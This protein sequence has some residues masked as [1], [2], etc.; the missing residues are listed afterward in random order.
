MA[1]RW[2]GSQTTDRLVAHYAGIGPAQ[3]WQFVAQLVEAPSNAAFVD[4][5]VGYQATT[6]PHYFDDRLL[7]ALS[8]SP[9][10]VEDVPGD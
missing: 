2:R 5:F 1:V 7:V 10:T 3:E 6:V 4:A 9:C 8:P